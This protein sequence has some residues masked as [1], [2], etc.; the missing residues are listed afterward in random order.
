[1]AETGHYYPKRLINDLYTMIQIKFLMNFFTK[2]LIMSTLLLLMMTKKKL[3][4]AWVHFFDSFPVFFFLNNAENGV[5]IHFS[6]VLSYS[7]KIIYNIITLNFSFILDLF[8]EIIASNCLTHI[9]IF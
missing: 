4:P 9:K 6:L 7:K 3:Y 5:C 1:M 8:T 2:I